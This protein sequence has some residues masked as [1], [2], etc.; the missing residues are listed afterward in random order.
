MR[1]RRLSP[2]LP[3]DSFRLNPHIV[4][5]MALPCEAVVLF[6]ALA[7]SR[8]ARALPAAAA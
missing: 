2:V 1:C 4:V 3:W 5:L 6:F 8:K 7:S